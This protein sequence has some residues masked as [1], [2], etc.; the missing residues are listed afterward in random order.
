MAIIPLLYSIRNRSPRESFHAGFLTG[1]VH[2]TS[3]LYWII[4]TLKIYG[5]L[6]LYLSILV[7]LLLS[8]YLSLFVGLFA[9]AISKIRPSPFH[10]LIFIP[11]A[12]VLIEFIRSYLLSGFP[13]ELLGYSQYKNLLL[14]QS[15]DIT[16]VLGLSY[17]II[18]TNVLILFGVL[19]F[20]KKK[21][22]NEIIH[23]PFIVGS[24]LIYI[25]IISTVFL[26]GY[27]R[28]KMV[29]E[30]ANE[31]EKITVTAIQGNVDQSVKWDNKFQYS[32]TLK[33]LGLSKKAM[34]NHPDLIVWP[35]TSA[36]F[37]FEHD[38]G[39]SKLVKRRIRET[40]TH[41]LIG[42]PS[43]SEKEN[44]FQYLNSAVLINPGGEITNQ[45]DK[46][47]L[48][49]YGEYVPFKK[50]FPFLDKIV[51]QSGDF[52]PGQKGKTIDFLSHKIGT[53]IC[54]EII[55]PNLSRAMARN[56]ADILINITND[57]W[58]GKTSAPH[59]HFSMTIFRAVENRKALVRAAN[60]GISGVICPTGKIISATPL[61]KELSVTKRV[62]LM[63]TMTFYSK[64]GDLLPFLCLFAIIIITLMKIKSSKTDDILL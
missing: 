12:W 62:P 25:F 54:F 48:V 3:L 4:Y 51:E 28:I 43:F 6:P 33:H 56:G 60:T 49:P 7:L 11:S 19:F 5:Y 17:L 15:A 45:Y 39:L 20:I 24:T 27:Y 44:N 22:C 23:K 61:Y 32:S 10:A 16:G 13:W 64:Y 30:M 38:I 59:Q 34:V 50:W 9:A 35:E 18:Y 40:K 37:Y 47:H 31:A 14:L 53:Q 52:K 46:V 41:F 63:K 1:F 29:A 57:A 2:Y 42:C 55:F 8:V 26:Y 21:W 58:F 36:P